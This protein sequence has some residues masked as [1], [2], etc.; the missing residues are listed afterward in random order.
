MSD[1]FGPYEA[2]LKGMA[3]SLARLERGLLNV[4]IM[5]AEHDER[6]LDKTGIK[7][8]TLGSIYAKKK[9]IKDILLPGNRAESSYM[10]L[11]ESPLSDMG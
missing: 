9:T 11:P 4:A 7:A 3:E 2:A 5:V 6:L 1:D 10:P 8:V